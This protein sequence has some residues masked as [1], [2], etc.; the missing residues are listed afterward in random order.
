M[1]RPSKEKMRKIANMAKA[2]IGKG[3]SKSAAWKKAWRDC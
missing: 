2:N 1:P 3:M